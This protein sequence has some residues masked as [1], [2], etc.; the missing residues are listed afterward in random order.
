MLKI[1]LWFWRQEPPL[2]SYLRCFFD[3]LRKF[4]RFRKTLRR[5]LKR[6]NQ[7]QFFH[8]VILLSISLQSLPSL[9]HKFVLAMTTS[10]LFYIKFTQ[11]Y[12]LPKKE[13]QSDLPGPSLSK[14]TALTIRYF[15]S[16]PG[17]FSAAHPPADKRTFASWPAHSFG[18]SYTGIKDIFPGPHLGFHAVNDNGCRGRSGDFITESALFLFPQ[19]TDKPFSCFNGGFQPVQP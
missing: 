10:F 6:R 12:P 7:F 8:F 4:L 15:P 18:S 1:Y 17:C 13:R 2:S 3:C 16:D 9:Y 5:D 11:M 14:S 19:G